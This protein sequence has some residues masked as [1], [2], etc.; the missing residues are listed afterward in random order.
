MARCD[1]EPFPIEAKLYL[2]D[3]C[4]QGDELCHRVDAECGI[5]REHARLSNKLGDRLDVL[6]RIVRQAREKKSIDGER[7]ADADP[8]G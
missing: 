4:E 3:F 1:S 8:E 5:D 6:A 2:P 7:P